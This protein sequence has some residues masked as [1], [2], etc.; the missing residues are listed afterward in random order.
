MKKYVFTAVMAAFLTLPLA[1]AQQEASSNQQDAGRRMNQ[2]M[3]RGMGQGMGM[4]NRGDIQQR[5]QAM[6]GTMQQFHNT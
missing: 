3:S 2:D 4:M 5:M 6:Q 1:Y